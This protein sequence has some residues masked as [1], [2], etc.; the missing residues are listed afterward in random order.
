MKKKLKSRVHC[1]LALMV[2][3][4]VGTVY[5]QDDDDIFEMSLDD[6]LDIEVVSATKKKQSIA[7]APAIIT[8]ITKEQIK[9]RNYRNVSE[10]LQSVAG[11][12]II[13]DHMASNVGIRGVSGGEGSWSRIIK[14][15]IDG[16]PTAFRSS[17]DNFIDDSFIPIIS[18]ERIEVIKGPNSALY[19]ADAYLGVVNIITKSG[20]SL[21]GNGK[22]S[23]DGRFINEN[24]GLLVSALVGA[25]INDF[26]FLASAKGGQ[27]ERS[28]VRP[29][30]IPE[31]NRTFNVSENDKSKPQ[32]AFAK[33]S[34]GNDDF[35]LVR[36]DGFFQKINVNGEFTNYGLLTHE[37]TMSLYNS[38]GRLKYD[39]T[40]F[41]FLD[42]S[43]SASYLQGGVADDEA[44]VTNADENRRDVAYKG[45]DLKFESMYNLDEKNI[46]TLG[47]DYSR[48]DHTF[49]K[50]YSLVNGNSTVR[51]GIPSNLPPSV[52]ENMGYYVQSILNPASLMGVEGFLE[53]FALTAGARYDVHTVYDPELTYRGA[54]V[55]K[56]L[57]KGYSKLL[58]GT[59]FKAPSPS[60]LTSNVVKI[61]GPMGNP[62][63][64]PERARIVDF[65]TVYPIGSFLINLG[66]FQ[67]VTEDKVE[68]TGKN[69]EEGWTN[70]H[71][72][73]SS[74]IEAIGTEVELQFVQSNFRSYINY[75]Y[76]QAESVI[77]FKD[78]INEIGEKK[79]SLEINIQT[80]LYPQQMLKFGVTQNIPSFYISLNLEGRYVSGR[81]A[82]EFNNDE[83]Y[84]LT[85]PDESKGNDN[86]S[87]YDNRYELDDYFVI[88]MVLSSFDLKLFG[89]TETE[90]A[91]K[92][93]DVFESGEQFPGFP[94]N[95]GIDKYDISGLG[96][97]FGLTVAQN[98]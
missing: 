67:S 95:Q 79:D 77:S 7:D 57:E 31:E 26:D 3:L 81:I 12:D 22:L 17:S 80:P 16:Q 63:L 49:Q 61:Q 78:S 98:F 51:P 42:L 50:F 76:V 5:S 37:N 83:N 20:E 8:V 84:K 10:A 89:E 27:L 4:G 43:F 93:T 94:N 64:T 54:V 73:N 52:L 24:P 29:I 21:E 69:I 46:F 36:L 23:V 28:G 71:P 91:L 74:T 92:V 11:L 62:D 58:Y 87:Y 41:E 9:T 66:A 70:P 30:A 19:G 85:L 82:S 6:M 34:Y 59:S 40:L 60:Q 45:I 35:G 88:D 96:R 13:T 75:S 39:K 14:V 38:Y 97:T 48:D 2:A 15:M 72:E 56:F 33:L 90:I 44:I 1:C 32:S 68:I 53:D 47:V 18:V 55:Y 65:Q 86:Q 25:K